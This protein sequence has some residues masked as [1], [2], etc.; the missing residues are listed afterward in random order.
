MPELT[1]RTRMPGSPAA[2]LPDL[3]IELADQTLTARELIR[4]AVEERLREVAAGR[5]R[6]EAARR[7]F[8]TDREIQ[9]MAAVGV[10]RSPTGGDPPAEVAPAVAAEVE[11]ALR[12][13]T[14]GTVTILVGGR[15]VESLDGSIMTRPGEPVVFLRLTPLVGG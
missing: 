15:Q 14:R 5:S 12:A 3:L 7:P 1:L 4:L 8:L 9:E 13:F 10:V 2:P 11:L 6:P